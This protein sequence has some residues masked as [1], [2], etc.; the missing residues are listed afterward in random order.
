MNTTSYNDWSARPAATRG[1]APGSGSFEGDFTNV[2]KLQWALSNEQPGYDKAIKIYMEGIGTTDRG[3][4]DIPGKAYGTGPTGVV[5]KV[6]NG[7][8]KLYPRISALVDDRETTTVEVHLDSFWVQP[9]GG[10]GTALHL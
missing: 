10:G 8:N 1:D 6:T 2:A 5:D 4:D 9:W 3:S 7:L